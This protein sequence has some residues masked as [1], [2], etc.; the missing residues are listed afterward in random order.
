[1]QSLW[2][3]V[4]IRKQ[5]SHFRSK[6]S[7]FWTASCALTHW[8]IEN[9][10]LRPISADVWI[11]TERICITIWTVYFWSAF[12]I[13]I[14]TCK[15]SDAKDL[16]LSGTVYDWFLLIRVTSVGTLTIWTSYHL[17]STRSTFN[18]GVINIGFLWLNAIKRRLFARTIRTDHIT[19]CE[20][21]YLCWTVTKLCHTCLPVWTSNILDWNWGCQSFRSI[22]FVRQVHSAGH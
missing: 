18:N 3:E 22:R 11:W 5:S 7:K 16:A 21:A 19:F 13:T 20:T 4:F 15:S 2:V 6:E 1:M 9:T 10:Y 12:G 8:S 14:G 17:R